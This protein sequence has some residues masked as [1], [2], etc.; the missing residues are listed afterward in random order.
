MIRY[1]RQLEMRHDTYLGIRHLCLCHHRV[2]T[3]LLHALLV[4]GPV[5]L[6]L[7][8]GPVY[9]LLVVGPVDLL[10]GVHRM[11]HV[12]L[13]DRVYI[14]VPIVGMYAVVPRRSL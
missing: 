12:V 1:W 14:S 2:M 3:S 7:V 8:V 9:L 10:Q 11:T 13:Q 4:V 6:V 5:D